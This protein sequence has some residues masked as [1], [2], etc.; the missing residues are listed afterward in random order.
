MRSV[1]TPLFAT[2]LSLSAGWAHAAPQLNNLPATDATQ[3][4]S[5][6]ALVR[7]RQGTQL[8][9]AVV[10]GS[11]LGG[12]W[13]AT[14]RHVVLD[15]R[16]VCVVTAERQALAALV[17]A[18]PL[19]ELRGELDL[20]LLWLPRRSGTQP[21]SVAAIKKFSANAAEFPVVTAT[22]YPT[23]LQAKPDGPQYTENDGL[24]LPLLRQP[25]EGGFSLAYTA[26]VEKGMS[27]GGVFTGRDLIGINGAHANPLWPGQWKHP[28]GKAV[29]DQL[30]RKL[31]LVALGIASPVIQ[32]SL[33]TAR[34]PTALQ[35]DALTE[36]RCRGYEPVPSGSPAKSTAW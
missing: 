4:Q 36:M 13:L 11:A 32:Q 22:G 2:L 3:R 9:S 29:N 20:S 6:T 33:L 5:V 10:V 25:L 34:A 17:I 24:L 31:E 12:Y 1:T 18:A 35:L 14:N 19:D 30:N 16:A 8:G 23:P 28:N 26:A 15:Q 27:G 7:D 21:L